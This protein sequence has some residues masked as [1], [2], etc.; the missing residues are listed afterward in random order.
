MQTQDPLH[1]ASCDSGERSAPSRGSR[2]LSFDIE[3]DL[4]Q[5]SD[6]QHSS[7]VGSISSFSHRALIRDCGPA[8]VLQNTTPSVDI[9]TIERAVALVIA[10]FQEPWSWQHTRMVTG[11][12]AHFFLLRRKL[13]PWRHCALIIFILLGFLE[14]PAYCE[15]ILFRDLCSGDFEELYIWPFPVLDS[16]LCCLVT[17]CCLLIFAADNALEI[18]VFGFT[19][20]LRTKPSCVICSFAGILGLVEVCI[21]LVVPVILPSSLNMYR[22]FRPVFLACLSVW[23]RRGV[24]LV[25]KAVWQT[26]HLYIF[27]ALLLLWF[28]WIGEVLFGDR[29]D[30]SQWGFKDYPTTLRHLFVLLTTSNYPDMQNPQVNEFRPYFVFFFIFLA[31]GL[32]LFM[33]LILSNLYSAYHN[34]LRDHVLEGMR[35]QEA[36]IRAAFVVL[37]CDAGE[38]NGALASGHVKTG[39]DASF[40]SGDASITCLV[41]LRTVWEA[42][43]C[44]WAP[45]AI[46][47][48]GAAGRAGAIF[49][50]V[51]ETSPTTA[52]LDENEFCA[53]MLALGDRKIRHLVLNPRSTPSGIDAP[54]PFYRFWSNRCPWMH[55]P[56]CK[57]MTEHIVDIL[58]CINT[59]L[60]AEETYA[61]SQEPQDRKELYNKDWFRGRYLPI[62]YWRESVLGLFTAFWAF[63]LFVRV[64]AA[65]GM[66]RFWKAKTNENLQRTEL[67][68]VCSATVCEVW[69]YLPFFPAPPRFYKVMILFRM[70]RCFRFILRRSAFQVFLRSVVRIMPALS[71]LLNCMAVVLLFYAEIGKHFFGGVLRRGNSALQGT[72][73]FQLEYWSNNFNCLGSAIMVLFEQLV[74]NNWFITMDALCTALPDWLVGVHLYFVSFY[75]VGVTVLLNV[76]TAFTIEAWSAQVEQM[77]S[78]VAQGGNGAAANEADWSTFAGRTPRSHESLSYA[79]ALPTRDCLLRGLF[80]DDIRSHV[81]SSFPLSDSGG[82]GGVTSWPSERLISARHGSE[83][84]LRQVPGLADILRRPSGAPDA[85]PG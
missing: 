62:F 49:Q 31:M 81:E 69:G 4:T 72:D 48:R 84:Y 15:D 60:L 83:V 33:N 21:R 17:A 50:A 79:A 2:P 19:G 76:L 59:A 63:E 70:A 55:S 66:A 10:G 54:T 6:S 44:V 57:W 5:C 61:I 23:A 35:S 20:V 67:L 22:M 24:H 82:G 42:F 39:G 45:H 52:G 37:A 74:V 36:A 78:Q 71:L 28:A 9:V 34:V 80:A 8:G 47:D 75:I 65:G 13:L 1:A 68:I 58:L 56:T 51:Q 46:S 3:R 26:R 85:T 29:N 18:S 41:V 27:V 43:Y 77:G 11:R 25:S 16:R 7:T 73:W 14:R 30:R 12:S 38:G 64:Q 40:K 53:L 32:F